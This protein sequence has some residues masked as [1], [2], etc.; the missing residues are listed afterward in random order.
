MPQNTTG[1]QAGNS[2]NPQ[3]VSIVGKVPIEYDPVAL[4]DISKAIHE[5]TAAQQQAGN[6]PDSVSERGVKEQKKANGIAKLAAL[7]SGLGLAATIVIIVLNYKAINAANK[8]AAVVDSTLKEQRDE[9]KR[10]NEPLLEVES[11]YMGF[12]ASGT[13]VF[14]IY[15]RNLGTRG[16]LGI[17]KTDT[18]I[19]VN[20]ADG[21]EFLQNPFMSVDTNHLSTMSEE[22][23]S[24][25]NKESG[26]AISQKSDSLYR[27]F[28]AGNLRAFL[29]RYTLYKN[30]VSDKNI[31]CLF[32]QAFRSRAVPTIEARSARFSYVVE[33]HQ[34]RN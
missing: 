31:A 15:T 34:T 23:Y 22:Y 7:A 11:A 21:D 19:F 13:I 14:T 27:G 29:V 4:K 26:F 9:F 18:I 2:N 25:E 10:I 24:S 17:G 8:S 6:A 28:V 33:N 3:K 1:N 30:P 16:A 5:H 12:T 32:D 20:K